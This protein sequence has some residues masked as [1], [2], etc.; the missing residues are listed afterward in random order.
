MPAFNNRRLCRCA[1]FHFAYT[2]LLLSRIFVL[3]WLVLETKRS[4]S[5]FSQYLQITFACRKRNRADIQF[6]ACKI[7][8]TTIDE[9]RLINVVGEKSV[10]FNVQEDALR[11][12]QYSA[13]KVQDILFANLL[14]LPDT[15]EFLVSRCECHE[16]EIHIYAKR[17]PRVWL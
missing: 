4:A 3:D 17:D 12:L 14:D 6:E 11:K 13:A 9:N 2:V 15:K 8:N 7:S 5:H 16:Y 10:R 1:H